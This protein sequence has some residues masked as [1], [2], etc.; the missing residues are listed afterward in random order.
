MSMIFPKS[1][2]FLRL[3]LV[4]MLLSTMTLVSAV[5]IE[6]VRIETPSGQ[7]IGRDIILGNIKNR[8]G[9]EFDPQ[10]L[11]EDIENLY[12][13]GFFTNV[14]VDV[15][16]Q[17]DDKVVLNFSIEPVGR[18]RSVIIQGNER[19]KTEKIRE[20][21][22]LETGVLLSPERISKARRSVREYYRSK[23]YHDTRISINEKKSD[24]N[25][26]RLEVKIEE[27]KRAKVA[28]V[29]FVGNTVFSDGKLRRQMRNK[30]TFWS[31]FLPV[32]FYN[33]Q[34]MRDDRLRIQELYEN[35]GYLDF[36]INR[37]KEIYSDDGK[38]VT[39]KIYVEEGLPYVV[40]SVDLEG[41][42]LFG[43]AEL[44]RSLRLRSLN[45][46]SR[47]LMSRDRADIVSR[48]QP[49]G[50]LD[51]EVDPRIAPKPEKQSVDITYNINEG[52]PS[53]IRDINIRGNTKTQDHVI[54]R[55]LRLHPGDL[56]NR[57]KIRDSKRALDNLGYFRSVDLT[58]KSTPEPDQK[59]LDVEV[60]EQE[61]GQLM[62]GAGFSSEDD[63]VGTMQVTQRNFDW[64]NW[65][66]F[67]G[68][69]QRMQLSLEAGTVRNNANLRFIEPWWLGRKLR[70]ELNAFHTERDEGEYDRERTGLSTSLTWQWWNLWRKTFG[71]E[72]K[73][74]TLRDF[75]SGVSQ[76][77]L[78]EKGAYDVVELLFTINRETRDN[79][80]HPTRGSKLEFRTEFQPEFMGS[81]DDVYRLSLQA[82]KYYPLLYGF[83]F[84]LEGRMGVVENLSGDNVAIFDRFFAGGTSTFRGFERREVSPVDVNEDPL[85]GQS[86]L[87]GTAELI[88]PFTESVR[89][90]LFC[91]AGN[92]W[93]DSYDWQLDEINTSVG[94]GAEL[95]LPIG[96]IR[97]DYGI[98][99]NTERE[100][101]DK[102]GRLHFG[103]SYGF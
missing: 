18:L 94:V 93:G 87:L 13:T 31:W 75:D 41:N 26:T 88:Y 40:R 1:K 39:L 12:N 69:G 57:D 37:V 38:K 34:E 17:D 83:I 74:T 70:L 78:D 90:R 84:K 96:P 24:D 61:T 11:S 19:L 77:L 9:S 97:I 4:V 67:T 43:D 100:H 50:Y 95:R 68:G 16:Q 10:T 55:E 30:P 91:D 8:P 89:G 99:V 56:A 42:K 32:G 62:L 60:E 6:E 53:Y 2:L 58:P 72:I 102:S 65:P 3:L 51:M 46:F 76:E 71:I 66:H 22:D 103:L 79:V 5:E 35:E 14:E 29:E 20:Q 59:D 63:L 48:Y 15:E 101:L 27:G 82:S 86:L 54:R 44:K 28:D 85:G 25:W 49:L 47:R 81:Y 23:G 64:R 73:E 45:T 92:V 98:P 52:E 33:E 7:K 80:I 36:K 21:I